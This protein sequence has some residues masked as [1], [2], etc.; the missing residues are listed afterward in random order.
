MDIRVAIFEDNEII[1][2]GLQTI[3]NGTS[4]FECVS[5]NGNCLNLHEVLK[6]S[7]PHVILMD[8]EMPG[9][10]GIDATK[11]VTANFPEIKVLIQTVFNDPHKIFNAICAGASGYILKTDTPVRQLE[12]LKE[13]YEGGAPMSVSIARKVLEFFT[14]RNVILVSPDSSV[15]KLSER[16][17]EVLQNMQSGKNYR[18]ISEELFIS[19]ETVRTHVK[20]I[21]SKL[22]VASRSEA[23]MKA[24]QQGIIK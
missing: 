2:N 13:V 6:K 19:Y 8:I 18:T 10:N 5:V 15:E 23:I 3:L 1:R 24:R 20:N 7:S 16:E 14:Q 17:T 4:G 22:H 21:Y 9:M 12:A 11:E